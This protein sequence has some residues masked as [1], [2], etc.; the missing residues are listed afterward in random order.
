[1]KSLIRSLLFVF[2]VL[3]ASV[4]DP[5]VGIFKEHLLRQDQIKALPLEMAY[6]YPV[7]LKNGKVAVYAYML[8]G[9][10]PAMP[11][12]SAPL[13]YIQADFPSGH[14]E[15]LRA[16]SEGKTLGEVEFPAE[17]LLITPQEFNRR[18]DE[19]GHVYGQAI[20]AYFSGHP[21]SASIAKQ[22]LTELPV[23]G[24]KPLMPLFRA[25]NSDFFVYLE[26]NAKR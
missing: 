19:F 13:Y 16:L 26:T 3:E 15:Q 22:V 12:V 1:M 7:P 10:P 5:D 24:K 8:I 25:T 6:S 4:A 11:K 14:I 2:L 20:L 21:V 23:F 17:Y 18:E 9:K